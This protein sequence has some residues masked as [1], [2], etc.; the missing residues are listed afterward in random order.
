M[1]T[2]NKNEVLLYPENIK[3]E[4]G[5]HVILLYKDKTELVEFLG[6]YFYEGIKNNDICILIGE[7]ITFVEIGRAHV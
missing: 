2:K 6:K 7:N 3:V 5:S 1:Q 4:M